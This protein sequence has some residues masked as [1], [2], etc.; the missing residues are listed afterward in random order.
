MAQNPRRAYVAPRLYRTQAQFH[1]R[2]E[3]AWQQYH[4]DGRSFLATRVL[5][6]LREMLEARRDQLP[7]R[8]K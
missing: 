2:G 7:E 1:A 3:A 4:R 5:N 8:E 6:E